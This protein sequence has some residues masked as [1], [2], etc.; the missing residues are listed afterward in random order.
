MHLQRDDAKE[1]RVVCRDESR[2]CNS[3]RC[4]LRGFH[5]AWNYIG[6]TGLTGRDFLMVV[7]IFE[8]LQDFKLEDW[9]P[10]QDLGSRTRKAEF[11][12]AT[13][14]WIQEQGRQQDPLWDFMGGIAEY[15]S[16]IKG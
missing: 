13:A 6:P 5:M 10:K 12:I 15:F 11:A 7:L 14:A 1:N 3:V 8:A 4:P 9:L 2:G 16:Q